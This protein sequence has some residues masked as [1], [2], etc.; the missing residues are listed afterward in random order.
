MKINNYSRVFLILIALLF[1]WFIYEY[2]NH[3]RYSFHAER[4]LV[5][6]KSSNTI[7]YLENNY[8][9]EIDLITGEKTRKKI[10]KK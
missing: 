9:I 1:C 2:K 5:L 3:D 8:I 6:D 4:G 7:Y 10:E